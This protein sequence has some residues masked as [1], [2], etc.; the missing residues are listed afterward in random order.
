MGKEIGHTGGL[1]KVKISKEDRKRWESE[2]TDSTRE[3]KKALH[4]WRS[5]EKS[6]E[7]QYSNPT[8]HFKEHDL[9]IHLKAKRLWRNTKYKTWKFFR[10]SKINS[11]HYNYKPL[12]KNL[13]I[14][15]VIGILMSIVYANLERL[16]NIV[17]IFLKVGSSLLVVGAFFFVKY[18]MRLY[19]SVR[20]FIRKQKKWFKWALAI[21][22]IILL[23]FVYQNRSSIFNPVIETYEKTDFGK[24][25]PFS[26][27]FEEASNVVSDVA[28][29]AGKFLG[30][31]PV[32]I[33]ELEKAVF[34]YSNIERSKEGLNELKFDDK[35][36]EIAQSHSKD[37]VQRNFFDHINPD[38]EDPTARAS[39]MGFTKT[40]PLG[41]G[42]YSVGI[43]E[44]IG[45]MP[46][47][48]VTGIGYVSNDVESLAKAQVKSWMRSPGHRANILDSQ[49]SHL[50]VGVAYD[51]TYYY[52][53]QNFW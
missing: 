49:Y 4:E 52:F 42:S 38:S 53:T 11:S 2:D 12:L 33:D 3:F 6:Q 15:V 26:F 20:Y 34:K 43:A 30:V 14:L 19:K 45:M 36:G 44:N 25:S 28:E 13:F 9:P 23:F 51:G 8:Y 24:F 18:L 48:D 39:R 47:G 7:H 22:L 40:K 16:N 10:G 46:T 17:L 41:G 1:R 29:D 35:L 37:M 21:V 32:S 50:G 31:K 5:D 27:T